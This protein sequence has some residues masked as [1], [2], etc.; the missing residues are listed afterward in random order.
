MVVLETLHPHHHRKAIMVE[1]AG[2]IQ[3]MLAAVVVVLLLLALIP[4]QMELAV[5]AGM[6]LPHQYQD[7]P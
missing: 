1:L 7:H 2:K 5:M 3:I 4:H 6:E